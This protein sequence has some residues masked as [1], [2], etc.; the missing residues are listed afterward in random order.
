MKKILILTNS[1][2]GLHSFRTELIQGLLDEGFR[3]VI[4]APSDKWKAYFIERGC[5]CVEVPLEKRGTNP[6]ADLILMRIY[7]K[8]IKSCK[9]DVVLTY[10]IKPNI[11]GGLAARIAK[12]PFIPNITG[13]GS[14]LVGN[15]AVKLL[16][17]KLYKIAL[18][19]ASC[20]FFQNA[21]NREYMINCKVVSGRNRLIPG[22]GVNLKKFTLEEYPTNGDMQLLFIG[23][24][25]REKG[26]DELL[27]AVEQIKK[28]FPFVCFNF[29]GSVQ[30]DYEEKINEYQDKKLINF[31]GWHDDVRS[32]I[33][34]NHAIV[35]PTYHEGMSNVLLESAA[36]GRPVLA[37]NVPGCLETFDEGISGLGFKVKNVDDLVATLTKFIELPYEEKKKM[38]L[39][40][41][42]KIEAEFDRNIVVNAYLEEI[43]YISEKKK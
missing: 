30:G 16:V 4:A 14:A 33:K 3:V 29:A 31:M 28:N 21:A 43:N 22:S 40:G 17:I 8:I 24:V 36:T 13:I 10:T 7:L 23:R 6:A 38:G 42:K 19:R 12:V 27:A 5:E 20:V 25:M 9:P 15:A 35:N 41:R 39:A 11:Y 26:V 2:G 1:I 37:S 18:K 32:I 34:A